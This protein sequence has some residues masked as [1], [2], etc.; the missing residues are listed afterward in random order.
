MG[1]IHTLTLDDVSKFVLDG[2][3][4]IDDFKTARAFGSQVIVMCTDTLRLVDYWV[5]LFRPTLATVESGKTLFLNTSG[6]PHTSLGTCVVDFF[7]PHNFHIT[8]QTIR[9]VYY[10]FLL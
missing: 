1:G 10:N 9:C 7:K 5:N 8:T 6:R 4:D 3:S 2:Q